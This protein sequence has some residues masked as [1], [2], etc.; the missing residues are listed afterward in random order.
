MHKPG[1]DGVNTAYQMFLAGL[2]CAAVSVTTLVAIADAAT[3]TPS[4]EEI[5][6]Q[7]KTRG[8]P[9][10]GTTPAPATGSRPGVVPANVPSAQQPA[11]TARP[12]I[13]PLVSNPAAASVGPPSVTLR[14]ITFEFGSAQLRSESID[15]LRNLGNALN[16]QLK[17]EKLFVIE[18]HTDKAGT[19]A[20][21]DELSKRRA[22]AVKDY[23][24]R[25]LGVSAD[26]LQTVGKGFSEPAD[27]RHPYAGENRR[28]VVVNTGAS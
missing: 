23:L 14:A 25:E 12:G 6:L 18:G 17:D 16:Q 19:R 7:L 8:L 28:V 4:Q 11:E 1:E 20:Y 15:T 24:V 22:D 13:R 3:D 5:G 10:L 27:P 9:T 21:N 2:A 26:R